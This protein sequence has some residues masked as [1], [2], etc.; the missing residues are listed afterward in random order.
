MSEW[1]MNLGALPVG[2][3]VRFRVWAPSAHTVGVRLDRERQ[4]VGMV[5]G[6][7][8]V[9]ELTLA[10][11]R[12]GDDYRYV[13]D[14]ERERPD[15][16]SRWQPRGV[17]GPSRIVDPSAF[18]WSDGDWRGVALD[19]YVL[20]EL[21]VGTFTEPGTFD[22]VID[23]LGYLR[24]L[25]VTAVELMPVAE[26]PGSRNWGYDGVDLY[27]PHSAYGG[28]D[29][30]KRLVDACHRER[31]AVVMDVVYNH[32]G[33]EGNYLREFGPYFT[34]RYETPWGDAI[35]YDG[36]GSDQVRRFFI[37]N[38]LYW[39]TEYHADALRLD[40]IHGIFD[41]S[42]DHVLSQLGREVHE[43]ARELGRR[44]WVIAES[45]LNDVRVIQPPELGGHGLDAQ[46]SDDWHHSL[47]TALTGSRRGYLEDFSGLADLAKAIEKGFVYDGRKSAY[48]Q[49]RHGN[50][51]ARRPGHQLVVFLQNHD[52]VA[53]ACGGERI[54]RLVSVERQKIGA[55]LLFCTPSLPLLFMGQEYGETA[56][57]FYFTSHGDPGL[58]EAVRRGRRE[59]FL[60][61]GS[62]REFPDPQSERT[63]LESKLDGSRAREPAHAKILQLYRD[64]IAL[65]KARPALSNGRKDWTRV[66]V[67]A[68]EEWLL[69]ER[70]DPGGEGALCV[71][72]LRSRAQSIPLPGSDRDWSLEIDTT[73]PAYGGRGD[74]ESAPERIAADETSVRLPAECAAVYSAR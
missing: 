4:A 21:H 64:L 52:Q 12:V 24:E 20:Y 73:A 62:D 42:A 72:N 40:A 55:A 45:D 48:R 39:V 44:V 13:L 9:F 31:L 23:R 30:L 28:P 33:P 57:F 10:S 16:V 68:K 46:W 60:A 11:A 69:L 43:R 25:G 34:S 5:R 36:P 32:L 58:A 2:D 27:A 14:D 56:P 17:H 66:C 26:F 63:F 15:P 37:D 1:Q 70:N 41:F 54:S 6:H 51:S 7:E 29:G 47:H 67:S 61:F 38:A 8:G 50:S 22:A 71:V 53:N 18:R 19:E 65:R 74:G 35:N 3:A 59:E 49:R